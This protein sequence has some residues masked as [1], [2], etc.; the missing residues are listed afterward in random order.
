[1]SLIKD[2]FADAIKHVT[3]QDPPP[4]IT[5]RSDLSMF[6]PRKAAEPKAHTDREAEVVAASRA[7]GF[8]I[9]ANEEQIEMLR[10]G[11]PRGPKSVPVT[12]RVWVKDWN[13]FV[14]YLKATKQIQAEGFEAIMA[15]LPDYPSDGE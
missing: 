8:T 13:K 2:N 7:Q 3:P 14:R 9:K 6:T 15:T 10:P 12:I 4:E 1:M 11:R 5:R